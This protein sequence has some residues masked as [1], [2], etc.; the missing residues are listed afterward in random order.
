MSKLKELKQKKSTSVTTTMRSE[1]KQVKEVP[2]DAEIVNSS[3][4]TET[5]E[6][7]NGWLITKRYD[8]TYRMKSNKDGHN[9]Y[10]YYNKK[11]F[12]KED[13]LKIDLKDKSLSEAFED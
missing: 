3:I 4:T 2:K 9:E 11:W 12:S 6:I 7:E 8:I 13:P 10:A 5:E 1:S